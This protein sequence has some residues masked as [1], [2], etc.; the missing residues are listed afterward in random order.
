MLTLLK[1]TAYCKQ[2]VVVIPIAEFVPSSKMS[3]GKKLI[4]FWISP[5]IDRGKIGS[6]R[7]YKDVVFG[8]MAS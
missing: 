5:S 4:A 2:K 8:G 3:K 7:H 1:Q 6:S